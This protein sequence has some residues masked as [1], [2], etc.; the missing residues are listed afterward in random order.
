MNEPSSG[1]G[2]AIIGMAGRFP[3]ARS[4]DEL[5]RNL[6][7]GE[8][9]IRALSD[10][11]LAAGGVEPDLLADPRFVKAAAVPDGVDLFDAAFFGMTARE[12]ELVDP[13][14]RVLLE[15]AWQALEDAGYAAGSCPGAVG[16]YAGA[17][18]NTYLLFNL[19]G[20]REVVRSLDLPQLNI[21][22]GRDFLATRVSYKLDL[23]GPSHLV[24]SAC[25]TSLVAVHVAAQSLYDGQCDMALAGGVSVNVKLMH[26]YRH[27][28]GGLTSPDG[29]CRPFDAL[30]AGTVF[31]GGAGVV[32][33]KPLDR[34]LADGDTIRAVLRGSAVNNDGAAKVGF[35]APSVEGQAKVITEALADAGLEPA[36]ISYV[37]THGTGTPLGDPIEVQALKRA[38]G[39]RGAGRH[40]CALGSLKANIGHLDAA[41]GVTSLI[42][43][44]LALEHR[45]IPPSLHFEQPNPELALDDSPFFVNARLTEWER[46]PSPRRAGVSAFGV[47]GTNAHVVVEE[48]PELEASGPSRSCQLLVLSACTATA[49]AAQEAGLADHLKRLPAASL[50]DVAYTLAVGRRP[51]EH[52]RALVA[53]SAREAVTMLEGGEPERKPGGRAGDAETPVVFLFPGASARHAGAGGELYGHEAVFR[54]GLDACSE[55]ARRRLGRDLP[56]VLFAAGGA[57][58]SPVGEVEAD[59]L[60]RAASF[61]LEH[62]LAGLWMSWGVRPAA[63]IGYGTGEL[64]AACLAGVL[65]LDDALALAAAPVTDSAGRPEDP[66]VGPARI[67]WI[68]SVTGARVTEPLAGEPGYWTARERDGSRLDDGIAE[69]LGTADRIFLEVGWGDALASRVAAHEAFRPGRV[70][71]SSLAGRVDTRTEPAA[72][73]GTL[74]RLWLAGVPVDWHG[75]YAGERR[76]R[77]PLPTYPFERKR[78]WI[79]PTPEAH[80]EADVPA[81][82]GHAE[83]GGGARSDE[84]APLAPARHPRPD[85]MVPYAPPSTPLERRLAEVWQSALGLEVVGI[86]DGFF[87]LGGDSLVAVQVMDQLSAELGRAIPAVS[88][89]EELT[90]RALAELLTAEEDAP[91]PEPGGAGE[92]EGWTQ[93]RKEFQERARLRRTEK[94][95][96]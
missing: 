71:L 95:R 64:V 94:S 10:E 18:I 50:A 46:G 77:I 44:V 79:E 90:V 8:E 87:E 35:T 40:T 42:K 81:A 37:E 53:G 43:T 9:S 29:H 74:G 55:V 41:A 7:A 48:A 21:A 52:R 2:I 36:A 3:G 84:E 5:W 66:R 47:G 80:R 78:Y 31:G 22:N 20:N 58:S 89:Y 67:P 38:W 49:L 13:Q 88:L 30:A 86:D 56:A 4:V 16:V 69:L 6:A 14:H 15:T 72:L 85:L 26:G 76:R 1:T 82:A 54:K 11:E 62:A 12:A 45:Q 91:A 51:F 19:R 68:S 34:A 28:E 60:E 24:Q 73:L 96:S 57:A 92:R 32:V 25:S 83:D 63:V 70:V 33:L 39:A 61:A 93:R 59:S 23:K 65:T 27:A 75:L 17:T